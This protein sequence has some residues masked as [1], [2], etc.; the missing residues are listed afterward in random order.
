[1]TKEL[2]KLQTDKADLLRQFNDLAALRAQ[3]ALLRDEA[4]M[5]QRLAWIA[6]SV[7]QTSGHKGAEA[8]V[9][10]PG[11]PASGANPALNVEIQQNGGARVVTPTTPPAQK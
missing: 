11:A 10:K 4:A 2:A 6:Q 3:V 1:L 8:L 5:N 9:T 7:Y